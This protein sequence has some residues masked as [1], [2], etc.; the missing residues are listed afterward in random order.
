MDQNLLNF[1]KNYENIINW[2]YRISGAR[3]LDSS[4][5]TIDTET[6]VCQVHDSFLAV[7]SVSNILTFILFFEKSYS[8]YDRYFSSIFYS[9]LLCFISISQ[10]I[11]TCTTFNTEENEYDDD[12]C[13][14]DGSFDI[15]LEY[16]NF[17]K[18]TLE[19][20][21]KIGWYRLYLSISYLLSYTQ[22]VILKHRVYYLLK[23]SKQILFIVC[24]VR[25]EKSRQG[26]WTVLFTQF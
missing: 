8:C 12:V 6:K 4:L 20:Q 3:K 23:Y 22:L 26:V 1:W 21:E 7:Q 14:S 24:R 15:D 5:V 18:K 25:E 19:H 16:L 17:S 11:N 10:E 9:Y 2:G 13:S